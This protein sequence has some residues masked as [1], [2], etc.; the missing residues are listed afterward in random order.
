LADI[1]GNFPALE[2]VTAHLEQWQPDR[3]V[4]AGD[5][6]NRGPRSLDCLRFVQNKQH[7]QGWLTV[8]GNHEDYVITQ[9]RPNAPRSGPTF[10]VFRNVYW[11]YQQLDGDVS[12]LIEMPFQQDL[13]GPNGRDICITHAS[14]LGIRNGIFVKTPDEELRQKIEPTSALFCVGHTHIPLIR[15]IDHTLVVNAGAVGLPFDGD[16]RACYAQAQ[17]QGGHWSV[18]IIRLEYD[19]NQAEHD[20][21]ETGFM[22]DSGAL[23]LLIFDEF[24]SARSHLY[25]WTEL[26]QT[27]VLAG[28]MSMK[29]SVQEYMAGVNR[30]E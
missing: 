12:A 2:A 9:A 27:Q 23:A 25:L 4:V 11:T 8:R 17:W 24:R 29:E 15:C 26:Y 21:F 10:E 16:T 5:I 28:E 6:V 22:T 14:L 1:H 18:E 19:R 13:P 30:N 20:F 3:I 7:S